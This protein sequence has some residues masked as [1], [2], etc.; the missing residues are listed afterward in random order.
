MRL[1]SETKLLKVLTLPLMLICAGCETT[2]PPAQ[3][4]ACGW[5][6]LIVP[7]PG[8]ETRMTS[9]ER[10]AIATYDKNL[11]ANCPNLK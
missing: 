3:S 4:S 9:G 11:Q 2:P 6:T 1:K 5:A 7:D 8:F 10:R